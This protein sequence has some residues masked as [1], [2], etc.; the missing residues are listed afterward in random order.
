MLLGSMSAFKLSL[1]GIFMSAVD[2][3]VNTTCLFANFYD[4]NIKI[5]GFYS[6]IQRFKVSFKRALPCS[7]S[8]VS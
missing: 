5:T 6:I 8:K 2:I 1:L 3:E 4:S 7:G